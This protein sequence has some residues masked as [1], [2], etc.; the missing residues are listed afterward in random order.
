MEIEQVSQESQEA[1]RMEDACL[2][3]GGGAGVFDLNLSLPKGSIT[4]I[5]GPSGCGKTTAIRLINGIYGPTSGEV[6][7]FGKKPLAYDAVDKAGIGY[8]PQ[9]FILYPNLSVEENMRFVGGIYGMSASECKAKIQPLLAFV[10][11]E[12]AR[13]RLARK[14]SGGMQRRL[15]L[16]STLL[17]DPTILMADEPTAGIDPILRARI[18][19]NFR[20]LRDQG[21]TLL[22]TTQYVGEAAY[23][24][25]VAVM[26]NGRL[27]VIDTPRGLQR[28]AMGGEVIHLQVEE[29]KLTKCV[30]F[31]EKL[32]QVYRVERIPADAEGL[33]VLVEDAGK[34]LPNLLSALKEEISIVP[35]TAEPY[36]PSFDEVFVRLI[37]AAETSQAVEMVP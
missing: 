35:T 1:V 17:H 28:R 34:E 30:R 21:K 19:E 22:V 13:K 8:I 6:R 32:P 31:L 16:A 5:I 10:E 24:D 23:C 15:M 14:L 37:R 2:D 20:E 36:L 12:A 9:H 26:R 33:Y 7:V 29:K 27:I 3:F 11:L 18:W 25:Q 4:G